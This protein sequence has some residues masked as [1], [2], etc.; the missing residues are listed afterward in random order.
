MKLFHVK[1]FKWDM[2]NFPIRFTNRIEIWHKINIPLISKKVQA[3][4]AST[5]NFVG[6]RYITESR[7]ITR[8]VLYAV[9]QE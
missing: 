9:N 6:K 2:I 7:E 4:V 1:V 8:Y 5:L 3:I